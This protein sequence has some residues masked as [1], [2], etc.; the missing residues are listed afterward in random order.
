M[1]TDQSLSDIGLGGGAQTE[2]DV[3]KEIE[4]FVK[5]RRNKKDN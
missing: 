5:P 2:E 3:M 1:F 4:D